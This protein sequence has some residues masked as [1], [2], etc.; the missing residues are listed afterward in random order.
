[1]LGLPRAAEKTYQFIDYVNIIEYDMTF[2][3][4]NYWLRP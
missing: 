2:F 4:V 3:R 1:M